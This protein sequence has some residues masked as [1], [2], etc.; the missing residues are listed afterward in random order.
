MNIKQELKEIRKTRPLTLYNRLLRVLS[1]LSDE[2]ATQLH[3][4]VKLNKAFNKVSKFLPENP[5]KIS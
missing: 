4:K 1:R 3:N 2:S 5:I